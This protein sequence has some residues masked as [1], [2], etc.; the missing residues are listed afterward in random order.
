MC[1]L[2]KLL[3]LSACLPKVQYQRAMF[4]IN[5]CLFLSQ[6]PN[7]LAKSLLRPL[8]KFQLGLFTVS[9]LSEQSR[10][11][12]VANASNFAYNR[13]NFQEKKCLSFRFSGKQSRGQNLRK[14][15]SL[16]V[17]SLMLKENSHLWE[18][19][20]SEAQNTYLGSRLKNFPPSIYSTIIFI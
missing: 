4:G 17:D 3:I 2:P 12:S 7:T 6:T 8:T 5:A 15:K 19:N 14:T 18:V 11:L 10:F 13:W 1:V 20:C 16:A 9:Q